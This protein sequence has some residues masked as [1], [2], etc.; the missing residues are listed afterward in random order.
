MLFGLILTHNL[1]TIVTAIIA[2][3]YVCINL[4]KLK[5]KQIL[6]KLIINII[7]ILCISAFFWMPLIQASTFAD[8]EVFQENAMGTAESF[9]DAALDI[10]D[11]FYTEDN[12]I[13]TF[14][15]GLHIIIMLPL[16]VFTVKKTI[17]VISKKNYILF[18]CLGILCTL[19]ATKI[20]PW[21][22]FGE[23]F[24]IL[25]F[26]WRLLVFS[27]F[28]FAIICAINI[29]IIIKNFKMIDLL[30]FSFISIICTIHLTDFLRIN[31][32]IT[33][34]ENITIGVVGE[35]TNST[36]I[37]MGKG[38]YLPEN[39][40]NNR[41]Y[42]IN[43]EDTTQILNGLANITNENKKG[44]VLTCNIEV[45]ENNTII[46]FPYIYYPGYT[47]T[48]NGNKV[49]SF[50]SENGFLAITLTKTD[51]TLIS[52]EYTGTTIMKLSKLLSIVFIGLFILYIFFENKEK[53]FIS[54]ND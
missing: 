1:M 25:Q 8:Y 22:L 5:D 38:E 51:E 49:E 7:F 19:M 14:E 28:F 33:D 39:S 30:F 17:N 36:I 4:Y 40:N 24:S 53:Y 13:Y 2:F 31:T 45:L 20:F 3:I 27:N 23:T 54:N 12:S 48:L 32:E 44:Q 18:L 37:G 9:T 47:V 52:V 50:E 41:N 6:K 11:I 34:I 16:S 46:E 15:I 35:D 42:I 21:S 43:R 29:S 10:K 26:P